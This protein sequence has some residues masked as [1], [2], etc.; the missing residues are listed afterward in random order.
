MIGVQNQP[1]KFTE[2]GSKNLNKPG[3]VM[4]ICNL[5]ELTGGSLKSQGQPG[6]LPN[7]TL[8]QNNKTTK[9]KITKKGKVYE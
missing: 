1:V 7:M 5:K 3:M 6:L 2:T 4:M 9:N 8:A